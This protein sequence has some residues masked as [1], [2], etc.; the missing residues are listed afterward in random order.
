MARKLSKKTPEMLPPPTVVDFDRG[1]VNMR[2]FDVDAWTTEQ[3]LLTSL[4]SQITLAVV[5][6]QTAY[7]VHNPNCHLGPYVFGEALLTMSDRADLGRKWFSNYVVHD[8]VLYTKDEPQKTALP[9]E[10][11]AMKTL[12]ELVAEAFKAEQVIAAKKSMYIGKS[13]AMVVTANAGSEGNPSQM[14]ITYNNQMFA[15]MR[16]I[17]Q[18]MLP[19]VTPKSGAIL[20]NGALVQAKNGYESYGQ[21]PAPCSEFDGAYVMPEVTYFDLPA[22]VVVNFEGKKLGRVKIAIEKSLPELHMWRERVFGATDEKEADTFKYRIDTTDGFTAR[23]T[24]YAN[25]AEILY[26]FERTEWT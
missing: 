12:P 1:V 16:F 18:D 26:E 21:V 6:A 25:K 3:A 23:I 11:A 8:I 13:G 20:L 7:R 2:G 14:R 10:E 19:V 24:F 4:K 22:I 9:S 15:S 5:G 17:E